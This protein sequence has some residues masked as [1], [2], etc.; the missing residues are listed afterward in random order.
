MGDRAGLAGPEPPVNRDDEFSN[1]GRGPV[2]ER[3]AALSEGSLNEDDS[4]PRRLWLPTEPV[5]D[6]GDG[7]PL[8]LMGEATKMLSLTGLK[9]AGR[10]GGE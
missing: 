5:S 6:T 10:G 8:R 1:R 9:T 2:L 7:S 3:E 4:E